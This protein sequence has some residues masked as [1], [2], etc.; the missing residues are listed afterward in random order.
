MMPASTGL[1]EPRAALVPV[2]QVPHLQRWKHLWRHQCLLVVEAAPYRQSDEDR[3]KR[4][5]THYFSPHTQ[6]TNS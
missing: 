3:Q 2:L 1:W 5:D 4:E 6:L